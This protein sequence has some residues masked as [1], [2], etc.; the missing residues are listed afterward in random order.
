MGPRARIPFLRPVT[1]ALRNVLSRL[2]GIWA[3]QYF[4]NFGPEE[5]RLE[6]RLSRRFGGREVVLVSNGTVA[7][8]MALEALG[9]RGREVF[10]PSFTFSATAHAV[11]RAGG[12]PRFTDV[13][14]ATWMLDPEALPRRLPRGAI[15]L[16]VHVFG[17]PTD[18]GALRGRGAALLYDACEAF[19]SAWRGDDVGTLGDAACFSFHATKLV[20]AGEG[21]AIVTASRPLAERLRRIRNFGHR[22]DQRPTLVGTNAKLSELQAAMGNAALDGISHTLAERRRLYHAYRRSLAGVPGL[23]LQAIPD[24]GRAN[25]Q[26]VAVRVEDDYGLP[27]ARLAERLLREGIETRCYFDPPCHLFA[28]YRTPSLSLPRTEDLSRRV[29]CLPFPWG[30]TPAQIDRVVEALRSAQATVAPGRRPSSPPPA[31][32]GSPPRPRR[33]RPRNRSASRGARPPRPR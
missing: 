32:R 17:V 16:P 19:G 31:R 28:V 26:L 3:R 4:S 2:R 29:L 22:G 18:D 33:S 7:L 23:V 12:R 25:G 5:R 11:V 10:L 6:A 20:P 15:L 9:A 14:A 8:E 1:P 27:R 24:G 21:G 30:M 13:D